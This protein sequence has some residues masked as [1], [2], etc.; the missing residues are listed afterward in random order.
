MVGL[1]FRADVDVGQG[2]AP[3]G[4][5]RSLLKIDGTSW[6][7]ALSEFAVTFNFH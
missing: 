1:N 5:E 7:L 6:P 4:G 3:G 2:A